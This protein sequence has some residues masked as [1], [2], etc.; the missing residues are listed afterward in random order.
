MNGE[1]GCMKKSIIN[2]LKCT[3][4]YR[5]ALGNSFGES[6]TFSKEQYNSSRVFL[7]LNNIITMIRSIESIDSPRNFHGST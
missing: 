2:I 5:R 7:R 6:Y 4:V 3:M 1:R